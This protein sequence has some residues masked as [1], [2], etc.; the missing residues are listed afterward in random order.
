MLFLLLLFPLS[1]PRILPCCLNFMHIV[2]YGSLIGTH[3]DIA[4]TLRVLKGIFRDYAVTLSFRS[5]FVVNTEILPALIWSMSWRGFHLPFASVLTSGHSCSCL[6]LS[7]CLPH[8]PPNIDILY[9][10][11]HIILS[12]FVIRSC[13]CA[14]HISWLLR[15][16]QI[17]R[18]INPSIL[19]QFGIVRSL[20][21]RV[22]A[23]VF[24]MG[25]LLCFRSVFALV[26]LMVG[27]VFNSISVLVGIH[28]AIIR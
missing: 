23:F 17:R 7:P 9:D 21:E 18:I 5:L 14:R 26:K 12:S 22:Q 15:L 8:R 11:D 27:V 13:R 6:I 28:L 19:H 16:R 3:S 24:F 2:I 20:L 25:S 4:F 10:T 1:T